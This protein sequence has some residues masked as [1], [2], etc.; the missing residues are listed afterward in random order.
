[1]NFLCNENE[2]A[3][4]RNI[5]GNYPMETKESAVVLYYVGELHQNLENTDL[6][7]PQ[8]KI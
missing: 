5:L 7:D 4:S 8:E 2:N 1:M 6:P 3:L